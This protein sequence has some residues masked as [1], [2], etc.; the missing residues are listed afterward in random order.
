MPRT[1]PL[2]LLQGRR[3][4]AAHHFVWYACSCTEGGDLG[5]GVAWCTDARAV[6]ALDA[7]GRALVE[8]EATTIAGWD[9]TLSFYAAYEYCFMHLTFPAKRFP[10]RKAATHFLMQALASEDP[11][12]QLAPYYGDCDSVSLTLEKDAQ[13][14]AVHISE[15]RS[16]QC[17]FE[18]FFDC[19]GDASLS[20]LRRDAH[21]AIRLVEPALDH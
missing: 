5:G 1:I 10:T 13:T 8:A 2:K 21:P 17:V 11:E 16:H 6:R 19:F 4:M 18:R 7:Q 9:E 14:H 12:G 15:G 3:A 20:D